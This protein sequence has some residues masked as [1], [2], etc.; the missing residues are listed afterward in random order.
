MRSSTPM[1]MVTSGRGHSPH[2]TDP[3]V[4]GRIVVGTRPIATTA[5]FSARKRCFKSLALGWFV[6]SRTRVEDALWVLSH[7]QGSRTETE[8]L[9]RLHLTLETI[10]QAG[11]QRMRS[12]RSPFEQ[13]EICAQV[14]CRRASRCMSERQPSPSF[15]P[16]LPIVPFIFWYF[17]QSHFARAVAR[18][19]I[20]YFATGDGKLCAIPDSHGC[21]AHHRVHADGMALTLTSFQSAFVEKV[22]QRLACF[23][24]AQS[25]PNGSRANRNRFSASCTRAWILPL[26]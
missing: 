2:G 12:S 7:L 1:R 4:P 20:L 23:R 11:W 17:G 22:D 19:E 10:I 8:C 26:H 5:H 6:A 3:L 24:R 9:W 18:A 14:D 15:A 13:T 21:V 16:L 25:Q